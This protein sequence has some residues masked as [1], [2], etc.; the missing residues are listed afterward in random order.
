MTK[1]RYKAGLG[2]WLSSLSALALSGCASTPDPI[3]GAAVTQPRS[4]FGQDGYSFGRSDVY[5]LRPTDEISVSVYREPELSVETVRIGVE[6]NVSLP[7]LGSIPASTKTAKQLEQ[8]LKA[9]LLVRTK[10]GVTLTPFGQAFMKHAR[11][12][13][14]ESRRA[15][16]EIGQLDLMRLKGLERRAAFTTS[17]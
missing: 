9:P 14:S 11:L 13:V 7:M 15:H 12:I 1:R 4:D 17:G 5:L 8:E 10:R 16:E 6:G 3:I 2:T